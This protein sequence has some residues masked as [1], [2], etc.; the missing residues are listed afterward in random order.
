[1]VDTYLE[2]LETL[3]NVLKQD[4]TSDI[5][6][7]F[8]IASKF[9]N[10]SKSFADFVE[11]HL[12]DR[13]V[14]KRH[15]QSD[16]DL[17]EHIRD[18]TETM[19]SV[20][21]IYLPSGDK[22]TI[23]MSN[24]AKLEDFLPKI[25]QL[26][27]IRLDDYEIVD[28][29]N[30]RLFLSEPL[31][32]IIPHQVTLVKS[33]KRRNN[34]SP[35]LPA[36]VSGN[37][38]T[39]ECPKVIVSPRESRLFSSKKKSRPKSMFSS[40]PV[41]P[42]QSPIQPLK[43][44]NNNEHLDESNQL[45]VDFLEREN[46]FEYELAN[47]TVDTFS[48]ESSR[49]SLLKIKGINLSS[50]QDNSGLSKS[51]D[52]PEK[53]RVSFNSVQIPRKRPSSRRSLSSGSN[54]SHLDS[55]HS[56]LSPDSTSSKLIVNVNA[57][58]MSLPFNSTTKCSEK[59]SPVIVS[60][61]RL[62]KGSSTHLKESQQ[63]LEERSN[64]GYF[65]EPEVLFFQQETFKLHTIA[66]LYKIHFKQNRMFK[67]TTTTATATA[68]LTPTI[69]HDNNS[70][71]VHLN[72]CGTFVDSGTKEDHFIVSVKEIPED[73]DPKYYRALQNSKSG[74]HEFKI[75][76]DELEGKKQLSHRIKK[77]L[78]NKIYPEGTVLIKIKN[79]PGI[80]EDIQFIEKKHRQ[81]I[82]QMAISVLYAK[83]DQTNP[84]EMFENKLEDTI[85][86][87][88]LFLDIMQVPS[89]HLY[90]PD[91]CNTSHWRSIEVNWYLSLSMDEEQQRRL[92]GNSQCI[93]IFTESEK[94]NIK[95][96]YQVGVVPQFFLVISPKGQE[97]FRMGYFSRHTVKPV[98]PQIP[99]G[100]L[101]S[102]YSLLDFLLTK[103]YNGYMMARTCPP[104][105]K[106]YEEPRRVAIKN[107]VDRHCPK[108]KPKI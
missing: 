92:V 35:L 19:K 93:I 28:S 88:K 80:L 38:P 90:H 34:S 4:T 20:F 65:V 108:I 16:P 23:A 32:N 52:I 15:S 96:V 22:K 3:A 72:F 78:C 12:L 100:Y 95:D 83:K 58:R 7:L 49:G 21:T 30:K 2:R 94:F 66:D 56:D 105:N 84:L 103:V 68:T 29:N 27:H 41:S 85:P 8:E 24:D 64:T 40:P 76:E 75:P 70:L 81:V 71:L 10:A 97:H 9:G 89:R 25:C 46:D 62:S 79:D 53:G 91:V 73:S 1:M 54:D 43:F 104:I 77:Y 51:D 36:I 57:D 33:D 87:Y 102:K 45:L 107:F 13:P 5:L 18:S 42:I 11:D 63:T 44:I 6:K 48:R 67:T 17:P 86:Q 106:L 31:S 101:F 61:K 55:K 69:S 50:S 74:W 47:P 98:G 26:R 59:L 37:S 60:E 82:K 39:L 14:A 99:S